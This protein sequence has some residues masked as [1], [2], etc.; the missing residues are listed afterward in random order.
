MKIRVTLA[1]VLAALTLTTCNDE[2]EAP[3]THFYVGRAKE[4]LVA[5]VVTGECALAYATDGREGWV[6]FSTW[7]NQIRNPGPLRNFFVDD[8]TLSFSTG[9]MRGVLDLPTVQY[10]L[11]FEEVTE[12]AGIYRAQKDVDG[13]R[14]I[15]GWVFAPDGAQRGAIVNTGSA[16]IESSVLNGPDAVEVSA[17][18]IS[19]PVQRLATLHCPKETSGGS[20]SGGGGSG[21][22]G[23]CCKTCGEN[24]YPC[25][26]SCI[27][28]DLECHQPPGCACDG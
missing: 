20:G 27:A 7:F 28:L 26:D 22:T 5:V 21:G 11:E 23:W 19:L 15:G 1:I 16:M 10:E 24:S 12:P 13:V 17:F 4:T 25:G 3:T 8:V 2:D 14:Y 18:G 9:D 6:S